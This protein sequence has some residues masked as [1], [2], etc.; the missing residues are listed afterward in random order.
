MPIHTGSLGAT[1]AIPC[2][3]LPVPYPHVVALAQQ[4]RVFLVVVTLAFQ[5]HI[6]CVTAVLTLKHRTAGLSEGLECIVAFIALPV[7]V[8]LDGGLSNGRIPPELAE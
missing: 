3:R 7:N 6:N 8:D 5:H 1:N 4:L 2:L